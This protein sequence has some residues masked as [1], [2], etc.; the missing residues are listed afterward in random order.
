MR[1]V[2][3]TR[4]PTRAYSTIGLMP[5]NNTS[6][7]KNPFLITN[8][9]FFIVCINI[10]QCLPSDCR[11]RSCH[12][13]TGKL[14]HPK[15]AQEERYSRQQN[16]PQ[17]NSDLPP[18][19]TAPPPPPIPSKGALRRIIHQTP[20]AGPGFTFNMLSSPL[21]QKSVE[22]VREIEQTEK[23]GVEIGTDVTLPRQNSRSVFNM[24]PL[25]LGQ[26]RCSNLR[27]ISQAT[28]RRTPVS[29]RL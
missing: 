6:D 20:Q 7:F 11:F 21:H 17:F 5:Q 9:E 22:S 8:L 15:P 26:S 14:S 13:P 24:H 10:G 29:T 4:P 19:P 16:P 28:L 2:W 12:Y 3:G 25:S 23:K 27:S 1:S 18:H